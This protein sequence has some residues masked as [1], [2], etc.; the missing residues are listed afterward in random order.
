MKPIIIKAREWATEFSRNLFLNI[1]HA[2]C[3][4]SSLHDDWF[5][6]SLP[7]EYIFTF[8]FT[9]RSTQYHSTLLLVE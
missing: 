2:V 9:Q 1:Y 8:E 7:S 5:A 4:S 3:S 6:L